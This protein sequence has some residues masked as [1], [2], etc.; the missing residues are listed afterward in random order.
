MATLRRNFSIAAAAAIWF[1]VGTRLAAQNAPVVSPPTTAAG[2]TSVSVPKPP[3]QIGCHRFDGQK[4][5]RIQCLPPA[6]AAR[7]PH[8][9]IGGTAPTFAPPA[10]CYG[11]CGANPRASLLPPRPRSV[12]PLEVF[13]VLPTPERVAYRSP[14]KQTPTIFRSP[15]I[16][17]ARRLGK[18]PACPDT[19][20]GCN[21]RIS[22]TLGGTAFSG[23]QH[24][25]SGMWISPR[26]AIPIAALG[27]RGSDIGTQG[28]DLM[29]YS[30]SW[31]ARVARMFGQWAAC[32][33]FL[34]LPS[35]GVSRRSTC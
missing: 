26:R 32:L 31:A 16:Q 14:C 7:L 3:E 5:E 10:P 35:A 25:A 22:M 20:G 28:P 6:V 8:M 33:G 17:A 4:W 34:G 12:G 30:L 2:A 19:Q 9:A 23:I 1:L 15:A 29:E 11:T 13:G 21:L 24:F 18:I 27:S